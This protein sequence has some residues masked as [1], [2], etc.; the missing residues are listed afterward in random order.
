MHVLIAIHVSRAALLHPNIQ[1]TAQMG[2]RKPNCFT[3]KI[4]SLKS[5]KPHL[6]HSTCTRIS[7]YMAPLSLSTS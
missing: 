6:L 1:E 4:L 2:L 3:N 7:K 5:T